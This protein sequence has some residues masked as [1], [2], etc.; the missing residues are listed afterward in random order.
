MYWVD[1]YMSI[2]ISAEAMEG[3]EPSETPVPNSS[4][5]VPRTVV[6]LVGARSP[7]VPIL[8][9]ASLHQNIPYV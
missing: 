9:L 2:E 1:L 7:S 5:S 4:L 8:G 3:L 6:A